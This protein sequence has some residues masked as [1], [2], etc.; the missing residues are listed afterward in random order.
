ML[1]EFKCKNHKSIKNEICF[2]SLAGK[3]SF[4]AETLYEYNDLKV[5]R[6]GVIY[7]AN[8]SGKSNFID[9]IL[10]MKSLVVNSIRYQPGE[11]IISYPHKLNGA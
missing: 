5:L 3:D 7:G 9:A 8:G 11:G 4:N 2:S 6:S 10:Y 1:L